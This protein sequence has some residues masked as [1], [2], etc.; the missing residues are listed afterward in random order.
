[1]T[2][3]E[4]LVCHD[5]PGSTLLITSKHF[6]YQ[7]LFCF[8]FETEVETAVGMVAVMV[9]GTTAAGTAVEIVVGRAVGTE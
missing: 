5:D 9:A 4:A 6:W 8:G 1:M 3:I 2:S 7:C